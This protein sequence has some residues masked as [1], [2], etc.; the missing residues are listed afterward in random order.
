MSDYRHE[1]AL[2]MSTAWESA[3][4]K[5]KKAQEHQK[6]QHDKK[7]K[8]SKIFPGDR[9]FVYTPAEKLGKA[10]KFARPFKGPYRVKTVLDNGVELLQIESLVHHC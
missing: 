6:H 7:A 4:S 3:R 1:I 9:V 10:Y 5:I 2:R 8:D